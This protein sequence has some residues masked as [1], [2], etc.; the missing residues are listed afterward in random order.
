MNTL[1]E[2]ARIQ[3]EWDCQQATNR[4]QSLEQAAQEGFADWSTQCILRETRE[5]LRRIERARERMHN[6][7][8]GRCQNCG[9][10]IRH[11]RL[12]EVPSAENCM[13]CHHQE[14]RIHLKQ[15]E[16]VVPSSNQKGGLPCRTT[17]F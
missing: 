6:G 3:L 8:Y 2:Q 16:N 1:F 4:L 17:P 12:S 11:D 13:S 10:P 5:R 15:I 9:G 7:T 14:L